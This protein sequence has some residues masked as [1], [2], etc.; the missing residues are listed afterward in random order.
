MGGFIG[1]CHEGPPP[2]PHTH[3]HIPPPPHQPGVINES[4]WEALAL[5]SLLD[6][7]LWPHMGEGVVQT[8][9]PIAGAVVS[10]SRVVAGREIPVTRMF[11]NASVSSLN[12]FFFVCVCD[13]RKTLM[14]P[15]SYSRCCCC[16]C[17]CHSRCCWA[18]CACS[19]RALVHSSW[20][21]CS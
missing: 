19:I 17:C 9:P 8:S 3:T 21:L 14:N 18:V 2:P 11:T 6:Q 15:L 20:I 1:A 5:P 4:H 12:A 16:C 13:R 7:E 10:A